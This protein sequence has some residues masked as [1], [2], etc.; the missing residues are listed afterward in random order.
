VA[1]K[2]L[3]IVA[4]AGNLPLALTQ[5]NARRACNSLG[6]PIFRF[7][8]VEIVPPRLNEM[9]CNARTSLRPT[10]STS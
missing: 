4:A 7:M 3:G 5:R 9:R 10:V 2:V 8:P 1:L 6:V